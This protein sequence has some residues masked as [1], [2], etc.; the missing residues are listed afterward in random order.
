MS[1][2]FPIAAQHFQRA[3]QWNPSLPGV[4]RNWA[5]AAFAAHD[6]AQAIP[7]L[8]RSLE[9]NPSDTELTSMLAACRAAH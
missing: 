5:R 9:H 4:E 2:Q 8:Q 1:S 3:A 6:C 7:P